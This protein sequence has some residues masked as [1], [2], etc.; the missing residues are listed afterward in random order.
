LTKTGFIDRP[1]S[2]QEVLSPVFLA[3]PTDP[4]KSF[5]P[6]VGVIIYRIFRLKSTYI[7]TTKALPESHFRMAGA[8]LE[9]P[10]S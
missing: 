10:S 2:S 4:I 7:A 6:S 5:F 1:V 9:N 3:P 8:R